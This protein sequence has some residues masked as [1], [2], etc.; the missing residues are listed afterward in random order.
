MKNDEEGVNEIIEELKEE[1][2]IE[3]LVSFTDIDLQ[4]KLKDNTFQ[5]MKF[6]D[7]WIKEKI[8]YEKLEDTMNKLKA[9]RYHFYRFEQDEDLS[10]PEIEKYY[11]PGDTKII[12]MNGILRKQK[13]RVDFFEM[14]WKG[15]E[16]MQWNMKCFSDNERR[17]L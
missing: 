16:K 10:K 11:I 6:K 4:E 14:C 12:Q 17:G 1:H 8:T 5:V 9:S 7:L 13:V 3:E 2:N 15:L